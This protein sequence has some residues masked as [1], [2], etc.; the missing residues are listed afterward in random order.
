MVYHAMTTAEPKADIYRTVRTQKFTWNDD[1]TPNFPLAENGPF[2]V[3]SGQNGQVAVS[4]R[5]LAGR[6][7]GG[8]RGLV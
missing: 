2:T 1:G 4:E 8:W 6:I 5:S 3:P 7:D